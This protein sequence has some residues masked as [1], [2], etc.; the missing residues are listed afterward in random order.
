MC[1][2]GGVCENIPGS[3]QCSCVDGF[4]GK[5]CSDTSE[6]S[7]NNNNNDVVLAV[8]VT[9][10]F[11]VILLAGIAVGYRVY[12]KRCQQPAMEGITVT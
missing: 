12:Q 4:E 1:L 5:L 10:A 3:F 9:V 2:N 11:F 6:S 7:T 8:S